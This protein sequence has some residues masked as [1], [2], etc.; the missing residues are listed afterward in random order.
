[1]PLTNPFLRLL[2]GIA[3][4]IGVTAIAT[5]MQVLEVDLAGQA[6]LEALVLAILLGV[7][8]RTLW[9]PAPV[10]IPG[11]Q[12]AAKQLLEFAVML[13]G[14]S[15]SA[16][17]VMALGVPMLIGIAVTVGI[18]LGCSYAISRLLGLP[19]R[20]SILIASGNSICGNS[21]IAVVAPV[22]GADAD[23]VAASIAF[24]AVLGVLVVLLLPLLVPVFGLSITQYGALA[25]LTVYAVPQVLAA[26]LP[27][28]E[29]ANQVGTVVKLVR[30]LMLGPLVVTLSMLTR[31]RRAASTPGPGARGLRISQLVPPFI[32]VFLA[33]ATLRSMGAIPLALIAPTAK[34]ASLLTTTSMAA[35][36]L[37]V[38][39]RVVAR[40]GL[41][42]CAAVT[43]SLLVLAAI[44]LG[45]VHFLLR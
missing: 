45:L 9:R 40:A 34:L 18:A 11:I 21:A 23:E 39:V 37:G 15:I 30:V 28:G 7:A 10:W 3:L 17:T 44:S 38:D 22:I 13:L 19:Q 12:F 8:V 14:A 25:G 36:G 43:A 5:L 6:Y 26:T 27:I 29:L 32:L 31:G 20:L 35:L 1:M 33:V 2:P 41:R 24:T 16:Q 42:V 4:C